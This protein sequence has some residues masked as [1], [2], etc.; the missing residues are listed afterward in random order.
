MFKV[1]EVILEPSPNPEPLGRES[2]ANRRCVLPVVVLACAEMGVLA[3]FDFPAC[4]CRAI[5]RLR[6]PRA[7]FLLLSQ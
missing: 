6:E 2:L 7:A 3:C 5:I 1:G 4:C